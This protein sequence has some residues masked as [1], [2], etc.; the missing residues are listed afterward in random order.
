MS[1]LQVYP[2]NGTIP[3]TMATTEAALR[4]HSGNTTN[5]ELK[6]ISMGGNS[7]L[8]VTGAQ[9]GGP[10][11]I[12]ASITLDGLVAARTR[13]G[14][15]A[16]GRISPLPNEFSSMASPTVG[17]KRSNTLLRRQSTIVGGN[18]A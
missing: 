9:T 3:T 18:P 13:G 1:H 6:P 10:T 17:V 11:M 2:A 4:S 7:S 8:V 5:F 12:N 16:N 14:G 15:D